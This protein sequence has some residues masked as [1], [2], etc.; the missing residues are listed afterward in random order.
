MLQ[1]C[2][3]ELTVPVGV[4]D[5]RHILRLKQDVVRD[6]QSHAFGPVTRDSAL[7]LVNDQRAVRVVV[8]FGIVGVME[9]DE[10]REI[11]RKEA[12]GKK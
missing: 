6:H 1:V 2:Q 7:E 11:L 8:L 10:F 5:Q 4:A 9:I 12:D 3:A